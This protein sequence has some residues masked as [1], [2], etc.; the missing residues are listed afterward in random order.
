[1]SDSFVKIVN[2]TNEAKSTRNISDT[3]ILLLIMDNFYLFSFQ[4][5]DSF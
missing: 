1:M 5:V 2:K 3:C 4:A